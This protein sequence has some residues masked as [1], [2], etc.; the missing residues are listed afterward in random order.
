V[1]TWLNFEMGHTKF[2][3]RGALEESNWLYPAGLRKSFQTTLY[4]DEFI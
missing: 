3:A 1:E 4:H 2:S